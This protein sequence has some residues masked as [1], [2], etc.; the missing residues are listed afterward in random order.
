MCVVQALAEELWPP[1]SVEAGMVRWYPDP[2]FRRLEERPV[3]PVGAEAH[4]RTGVR[5]AARALQEAGFR[6]RRRRRPWD[7]GRDW[8]AD[9][10][11][12]RVADGARPGESSRNHAAAAPA[13][14]PAW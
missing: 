3:A 4:W 1:G 7:P 2:R 11:V 8:S 6:L 14:R 9:H 5:L 13:Q 10:V 12:Y